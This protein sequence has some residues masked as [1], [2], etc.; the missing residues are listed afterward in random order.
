MHQALND[1]IKLAIEYPDILFYDKPISFEPYERWTRD[2]IDN[3]ISV[4]A[5]ARTVHIIH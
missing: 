5:L 4:S 3:S 1:N 2:G